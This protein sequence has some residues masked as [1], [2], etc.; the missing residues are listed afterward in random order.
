MHHNSTS[1]EKQ[2]LLWPSNTLASEKT[3]ALHQ[4]AQKH[5]E[6]TKNKGRGAY[7]DQAGVHDDS[8]CANL[9]QAAVQ[10]QHKEAVHLDQGRHSSDDKLERL[11][12]LQV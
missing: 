3:E 1:C 7:A 8:A 12:V 10:A 11:S 6:N 5:V 4:G 9:Q 2:G